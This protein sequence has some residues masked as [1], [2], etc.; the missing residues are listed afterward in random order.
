MS[1][2]EQKKRI[3]RRLRMKILG[4]RKDEFDYRKR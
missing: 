4:P 2:L 3:L 1:D